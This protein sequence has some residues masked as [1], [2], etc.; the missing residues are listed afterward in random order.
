MFY[1]DCHDMFCSS[2]LF[3]NESD[4]ERGEDEPTRAWD[5]LLLNRILIYCK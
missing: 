3:D 1:F 4:H 2:I 5:G